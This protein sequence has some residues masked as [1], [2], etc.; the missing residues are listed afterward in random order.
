MLINIH[1]NIKAFQN[2]VSA[3]AY[4]QIPFATA[5][6]LTALAKDVRDAEKA[7]E[8]KVLDRPKPFTE[9]AIKVVKARKDYPTAKVAMQDIAAGYL[10]PYEFGG[11]NK[12]NSRA[13]LKPIGAVA[14]LDQYGNLPRRL[15]GQLKGRSD[16]F[17]GAVQTKAGPVNGVWQ[18][19][20]G[21]GD[22]VAITRVMKKTGKVRISKTARGV[23]AFGA[24]APRHLKLLIKFEDAHD[25]RQHLGWFGVAG[26]T[27]SKQFN[28]RFGQALDKAIATAK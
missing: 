15:L 8:K 17:I 23:N 16:V 21:E 28:R 26:R 1:S 18:R 5:Q 25:V 14:D 27:V 24:G 20:V 11:R 19:A 2:K 22:K 12:L 9:N 4:K 10:E 7:N 13:L 3:T 6:A